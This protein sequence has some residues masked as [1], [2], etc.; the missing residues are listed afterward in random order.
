MQFNMNYNKIA[1]EKSTINRVTISQI[2][3]VSTPQHLFDANVDY[4]YFT[5]DNLY[6][7]HFIRF[8]FFLFHSFF[9]P[10]S[11]VLGAW[12]FFSL[13]SFQFHFGLFLFYL[14]AIHKNFVWWIVYVGPNDSTVCANVEYRCLH[15]VFSNQIYCESVRISVF[16]LVCVF[17]CE[18]N[19]FFLW[20]YFRKKKHTTNNKC[21]YIECVIC[22][23][24]CAVLLP[25]FARTESISLCRPRFG[26]CLCVCLFGMCA[27]FLALIFH[28]EFD[29]LWRF[30]TVDWWYFT[31]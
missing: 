4:V 10:L 19:T 7:Q 21:A 26:R 11:T 24:V 30:P 12:L 29:G 13:L 3:C 28:R 18:I 1:Q 9:L 8:G 6:R 2:L 27:L 14:F 23:I 22:V 15:I 5:C 16:L 17:V 31:L 25:F 20:F